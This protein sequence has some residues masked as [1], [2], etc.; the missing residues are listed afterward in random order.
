MHLGLPFSVQHP[1]QS[2]DE[3]SSSIATCIRNCPEYYLI[4][5]KANPAKGLWCSGKIKHTQF[6]DTGIRDL[7]ADQPNS[8]RLLML[9]P[10]G[11]PR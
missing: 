1:A 10:Y 3:S 5:S 8:I 6:P 9:V 7:L 11:I 4:S 2:V